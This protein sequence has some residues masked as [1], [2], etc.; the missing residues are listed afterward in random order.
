MRHLAQHSTLKEIAQITAAAVTAV[1]ITLMLSM[2]Y[3][4]LLMTL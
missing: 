1:A 4:A 2:T 3:L